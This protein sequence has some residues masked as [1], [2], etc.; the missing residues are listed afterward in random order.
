MEALVC[1]ISTAENPVPSTS[2]GMIIR[3]RFSTGS[4]VRATKPDAGS[5]CRSTENS[6]M[7]SR[8]SQKCGTDSPIRPKPV[9]T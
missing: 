2:A 8:Q 6:R 9:A 3:R 7:P 5:Q 1:R 4:A